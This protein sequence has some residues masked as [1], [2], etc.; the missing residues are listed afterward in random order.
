MDKKYIK[1][2]LEENP[3]CRER[4]TKDIFLAK[5]ILQEFPELTMTAITPVKLGRMFTEY[6]TLDRLFRQ[7]LEENEHLRGS[8][9]EQKGHLV[10]ARQKSLGYNV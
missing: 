8:D 4:K 3:S 10:K 1:K 6:N 9:Y 2:I 7:V 5:V